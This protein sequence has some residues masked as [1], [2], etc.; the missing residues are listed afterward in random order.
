MEPYQERVM[1]EEIE[2][3]ECMQKLWKFLSDEKLSSALAPGDRHLL[4]LL[5]GAMKL[6]SDVLNRRIENFK[7]R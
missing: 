2:L 1:R 5:L 3:E 4:D 7:H 6:Y